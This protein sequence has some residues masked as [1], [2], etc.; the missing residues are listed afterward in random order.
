[1]TGAYGQ[2]SSEGTARL[3]MCAVEAPMLDGEHY[4][5][6]GCGQRLM[7]IMQANYGIEC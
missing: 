4:I 2:R 5:W 7:R 3:R 1:M 6:T